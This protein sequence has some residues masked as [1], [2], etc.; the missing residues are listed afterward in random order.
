MTRRVVVAYPEVD[1]L[2]DWKQ[3]LAVRDRYDPLASNIA[4]HL[5]LVFPFADPM[6]DAELEKHLHHAVTDIPAFDVILGGIT[7]HEDEYLFLNV[8]RGNDAVIHL[9]DVLYGGA[10]SR[11]LVRGHTF[12][13]HVTVGRLST[14]A[15]AAALD[16][17]AGLD[18]PMDAHVRSISVYRIEPNGDRTDLFALPL[19]PRA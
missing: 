8:K 3:V 2:D 18:K 13:P 17:T 19:A 6:S 11:H 16:A 14:H 1:N 12:V 15:L 10:L 5:T 7:A 4:A 9:H